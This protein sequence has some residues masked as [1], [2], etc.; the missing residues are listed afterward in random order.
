MFESLDDNQG[1]QIN[2]QTNRIIWVRA[3]KNLEYLLL[4]LPQA[5]LKDDITTS[6][7]PEVRDKLCGCGISHVTWAPYHYHYQHKH[8]RE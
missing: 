8:S 6:S 1:K 7:S 4:L 3:T 2:S 5:E